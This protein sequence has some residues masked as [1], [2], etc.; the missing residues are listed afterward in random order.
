[1]LNML[2]E[3]VKK[4]TVWDIGLTKIAI[5]FFTIIIV[6]LLPVLLQIRYS[7]LIILVVICGARPL[8]RFLSDK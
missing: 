2:N 3:R 8:Y 7:V 5:F 4:L 6:K 1:M